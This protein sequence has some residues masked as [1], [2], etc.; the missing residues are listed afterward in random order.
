MHNCRDPNETTAGTGTSDLVARVHQLEAE[1]NRLRE[2]LSE[3]SASEEGYRAL[4]EMMNDGLGVQDEQGVFVYVNE[5]L[6]KMI[7]RPRNEIL[8]APAASFIASHWRSRYAREMTHEER[9]ERRQFEVVLEGRDGPNITA[10]VSPAPILSQAGQYIGSFAVFTDITELRRSE[11]ALRESED[12]LRQILDNSRDIV[13]K[14]NLRSRRVEYVS[15]SSTALSGFTPEEM[16]R[17][18]AR[19]YFRRVHPED[20]RRLLCY[21]KAIKSV[22]TSPGNVPPTVEYRCRHKDDTYRWI[23]HLSVALRSPDGTVVAEV[24]TLRDITQSKETEAALRAAS[25]MEATA[26]L[27]GGIAHD[28]NNLMVGVMGNCEL[29]QRR[30]VKDPEATRM[31]TTIDTCAQ[32]VGDLVRQ[33]LAFARGGKYRP[34]TLNLNTVV[35]EMFGM[36]EHSVPQGITTKRE[37]DP[38]LLDVYADSGQMGQVFASIYANAVEAIDHGGAIVIRT[39]N[40]D[41]DETFAHN[42]PGLTPGRYACVTMEDTGHGMDPNVL[43]RVFEPFFTTKS[44][45]RGLGLAAVYGIVKNHGGCVYVSSTPGKGSCVTVYFPAVLKSSRPVELKPCSDAQVKTVVIVD[46]EKFIVNVIKALLEQCGYHVLCASNG[47][48]AVQL[49]QSYEGSI[50]LVLLDMSMPIMDGPKAYPLL[51][52]ARPALKVIIVSGYWLDSTV[53]A[54]LDAGASAFIHKPFRANFLLN[55]VREVLRNSH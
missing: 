42:H 25:R 49:A 10:L 28:L 20:R 52:Q 22:D 40:T 7:G 54:L 46:D 11:A 47:A 12:L 9:G 3:L 50:D 21:T 18:G 17:M 2:N 51:M 34:S 15:P 38:D 16:M 19:G 29:L 23:G 44:H 26:T 6:C 41:V 31:L 48:E 43:G 30:F 32:K 24:G 37:L 53:Q 5:R 35:M 4:V 45:G 36:E 13:Y 27:A 39:H 55:T 1:G 33:V 8:G 14:L